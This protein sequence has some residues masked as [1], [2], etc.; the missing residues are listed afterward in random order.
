M[1]KE[2]KE[3]VAARASALAEEYVPTYW[4]CAQTTFTAI[5]NALREAGVELCTKEDQEEMF[6]GLVGLSGGYG[7]LGIG[8]CGALAGSAFAVS[9]FSGIDRQKQLEDKDNRRLAFENVA[10]T[11]VQKF[12]AEFDGLSCRAV[13][14][15]RWGKWCDSW[16]P[17][18][19]QEFNR[20]EQ[21]R[22]CMFQGRCTMSLAAKWTTAYILDLKD[23]PLTLAQVKAKFG[24]V[25]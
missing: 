9:L 7:N 20:D 17:K 23:K 14:W 10:N 2:E 1:N 5:V 6:K 8:N 16:D 11:I 4:G 21:A 12:I 19:K 24:E 3:K 18:A 15:A 25:H 22:G 13:N